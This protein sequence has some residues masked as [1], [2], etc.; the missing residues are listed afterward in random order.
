MLA[1]RI[2]RDNRDPKRI[3]W[4]MPEHERG[5]ILDDLSQL[6]ETFNGCFVRMRDDNRCYVVAGKAEA[7]IVEVLGVNEFRRHQGV[8]EVAQADLSQAEEW[9]RDDAK[10]RIAETVRVADCYELPAY[11]VGEGG[12]RFRVAFDDAS[13]FLAVE[14]LSVGPFRNTGNRWDLLFKTGAAVDLLIGADETAE[15]VRQ[16]PVAGDRRLLLTVSADGPQAV[17]YDMVVPG[18]PEDK[19][20]KVASPVGQTVVDVVR[21]LDGVELVHAEVWADPARMEGYRGYIVEARIPLAELGFAAAEGLRLKMDLGIL[22]ADADGGTTVRR[23]YW[24]NPLALTVADIPS[25][26]RVQPDMWGWIRLR[27]STRGPA[28]ITPGDL[29][30]DKD[31]ADPTL[32]LDLELE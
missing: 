27:D 19:R 17:L 1:G 13:L 7:S 24:A 30:D 31:A 25:E 11:P 32:D 9:E 29:T 3:F 2:F 6:E 16:A 10:R 15:S 18:T 23:F 21:R 26:A 4:Q 5:M 22:Q 14:A 12:S 8:A 20:W 28:L